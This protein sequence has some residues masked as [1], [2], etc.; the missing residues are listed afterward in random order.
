MKEMMVA[1]IQPTVNYRSN[2]LKSSV[3]FSVP[4][5]LA[6]QLQVLILHV[7]TVASE[8]RP[9]YC[10]PNR[11]PSVICATQKPRYVCR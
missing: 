1:T 8:N 3:S 4:K 11:F 7:R 9:N 10:C 6:I 5:T 2:G